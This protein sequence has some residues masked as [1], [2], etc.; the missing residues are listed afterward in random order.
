MNI[1]RKKKGS[2]I[3]DM[4]I[5]KRYICAVQNRIINIHVAKNLKQ[6]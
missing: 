2:H 3:K 5:I 6:T 1:R 4:P